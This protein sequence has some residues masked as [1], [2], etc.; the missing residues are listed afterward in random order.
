[1]EDRVAGQIIRSIGLGP[2][3]TPVYTDFNNL[4]TSSSSSSS[5]FQPLNH[6]HHHHQH[7][8]FGHHPPPQ[9]P[10][11][12]NNNSVT[13]RVVSLISMIGLMRYLVFWWYYLLIWLFSN[14]SS[15]NVSGSF[16][17]DLLKLKAQKEEYQRLFSELWS[18]SGYLDCIICPGE[19]NS[20]R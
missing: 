9:Q 20:V 3:A 11:H 4:G 6:N 10:P 18:D 15:L 13:S 5:S 16:P 2:T 8:L 17:R 19:L 14:N 7:P 1:M 12:M